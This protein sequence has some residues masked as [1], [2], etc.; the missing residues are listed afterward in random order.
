MRF[1]PTP[2]KNAFLIDLEKR[3]DERG[4]F[5]RLFCHNEFADHDLNSNFVQ[6]NN[7]FS[8][9]KGT[10]RGLHYQLEPMAEC[11]LVRCIQGS[12]YDVILD[13]R[14]E[15][16]TFGKWF[17]AVLSQNNRQMMYIPKGFA[18]GF[19]T[20]E[21]NTELLYFVSNPY[22]KE[23]ERGVRWNDPQFNIKWPEH[24]SVISERDCNFSDFLSHQPC[25]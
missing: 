18:H 16:E 25:C 23:L 9:E 20:L 2:L 7:S 14:Q 3:S 19:M 8:K 6:V 21:P 5:A 11:K 1:T 17:S 4:F 22:S 24:P 15:S 10:L 12:L 13:L